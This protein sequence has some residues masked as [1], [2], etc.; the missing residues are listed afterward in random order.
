YSPA[1]CDTGH[2]TSRNHHGLEPPGT[3]KNH[4]T[5]TTSNDAVRSIMLPP[6]ISNPRVETVVHHSHH[7]GGVTEERTSSGDRVQN[8]VQSDLRRRSHRC[9][10]QSFSKTP[11]SS[12]RQPR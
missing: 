4:S 10:I 11:Y 2:N 5:Q 1:A 3:L 6:S 12:Q 8:T 9:P 7:T